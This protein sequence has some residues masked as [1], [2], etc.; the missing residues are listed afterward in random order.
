[1][2][3]PEGI[4]KVNSSSEGEVYQRLVELYR[5][6]SEARLKLRSHGGQVTVSLVE[7]ITKEME[8]WIT[9]VAKG[10]GLPNEHLKILLG[11][12]GEIFAKY[13]LVD[14]VAQNQ[15]DK[16][17]SAYQRGIAPIE[18]LTK[19]G[20]DAISSMI[21]GRIIQDAQ[22]WAKQQPKQED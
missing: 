21:L 5:E 4:K 1:M 19:E 2:K 20:L 17:R 11:C 15:L 14:P 7:S 6:E 9:K 3:V 22:T 10:T 18:V 8:D 13:K 12:R 16:M